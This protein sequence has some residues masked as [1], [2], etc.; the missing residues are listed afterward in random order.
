MTLWRYM[1]AAL[2]MV[3]SCFALLAQEMSKNQLL[4]M[5]YAKVKEMLSSPAQA[6]KLAAMAKKDDVI[7]MG[8]VAVEGKKVSMKG[9][10]T[11]ANCYLSRGLH[12]PATRSAPKLAW[13]RDH[14]SCFSPRMA[15]YISC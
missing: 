7:L 14:R 9:E 10:L 11:G 3:L 15:K 5:P 1:A 2:F 6:A 12:G 4:D 13:P 8:G